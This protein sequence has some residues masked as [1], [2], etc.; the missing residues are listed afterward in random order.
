M[1]TPLRGV[2]PTNSELAIGRDAFHQSVPAVDGHVILHLPAL[3]L[4][5]ASL[6]R[7]WAF[8][9]QVI[10][11]V[12]E[13]LACRISRSEFGRRSTSRTVTSR[14]EWIICCRGRPCL[15]DA[16]PAEAMVALCQN[17]RIYKRTATDRTHEVVIVGSDIVQ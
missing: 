2:F 15:A 8:D 7:L 12:D 16:L 9:F 11:D 17:Y 10:E 1:E 5:S 6:I 14:P 13:N 3:D 4:C